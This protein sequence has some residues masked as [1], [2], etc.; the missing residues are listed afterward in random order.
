MEQVEFDITGIVYSLKTNLIVCRVKHSHGYTII[1][2]RRLF[3][4]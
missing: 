2:E 1:K 4:I 3:S